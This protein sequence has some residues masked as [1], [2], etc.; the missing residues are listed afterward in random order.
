MRR[1]QPAAP[2]RSERRCAFFHD[3]AQAL[4]DQR[5][6][7]HPAGAGMAL[8]GENYFGVNR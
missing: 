7:R 4:L 3:I 5:R 1:S 2:A 8:S 6:E